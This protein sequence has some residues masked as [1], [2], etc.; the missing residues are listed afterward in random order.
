MP[1]YIKLADAQ[2]RDTQVIVEGAE[3]DRGYTYIGPDGAPIRYAKLILSPQGHDFAELSGTFGDAEAVAEALIAGD[4]EVDPSLVGRE[5]GPSDRVYVK[6]DG[7]ILLRARYVRVVIDPSG[8]EVSREPFVD[9]MQTVNDETPLPWTGRL[10]SVDDVVRRFVIS[11]TVQLRHVDGLTFDF[12][13][14]IAEALAAERKMLLVGAGAK[15]A[16][17][18]VFQTNGSRYRGF[19]EGRVTGDGGV[20]VLLHLS[21]LELKAV[22]A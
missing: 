6:A 11:R 8:E 21:N 12:L 3:R 19:L 2:R 9:V 13:K 18:L 14:G 16:E 5:V 7:T 22:G 17:P 15:G 1:R 10:L 20:L 4:P